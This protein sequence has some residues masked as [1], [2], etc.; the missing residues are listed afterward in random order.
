[1]DPMGV[2]LTLHSRS[3]VQVQVPVEATF[4]RAG[5]PTLS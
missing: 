1:M 2:L 3:N 4:L 5:L